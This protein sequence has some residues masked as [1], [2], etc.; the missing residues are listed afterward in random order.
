MT[1]ATFLTALH[2]AMTTALGPTWKVGLADD[3]WAAM[4]ILGGSAP[5]NVRLVLQ[6]GKLVPVGTGQGGM[7][8]THTVRAI[9]QIRR[10]MAHDATATA[11]GELANAE[12][13]VRLHMLALFF[14]EAGAPAP[15]APLVSGGG[16]AHPQVTQFTFGGSDAY[17]SPMEDTLLE[18]PARVADFIHTIALNS[19]IAINS[20]TI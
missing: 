9:V 8:C 16:A 18:H 17:V 5:G 1:I 12:E 6:P 3:D 15:T 19:P 20:V 4:E 10:G 14:V 13:M 7:V 2:A 11:L